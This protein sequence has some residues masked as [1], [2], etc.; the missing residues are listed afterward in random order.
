MKF[1]EAIEKACKLRDEE[2]GDFVYYATICRNDIE[3]DVQDD[4]EVDFGFKDLSV[5]DF[6]ADDWEVDGE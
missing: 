2:K 4:G 1:V 5:D 3:I 6:T